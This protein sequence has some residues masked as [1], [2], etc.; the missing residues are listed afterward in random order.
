V[1]V[2]GGDGA[3]AIVPLRLSW[4]RRHHVGVASVRGRGKDEREG[5]RA[6]GHVQGDR[7][8]DDGRRGKDGVR[9]KP[10]RR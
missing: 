9:A 2:G 3:A 10:A 8:E 1:R 4:R 5:G 7:R 6:H